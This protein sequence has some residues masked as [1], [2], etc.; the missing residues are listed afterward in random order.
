M[1]SMKLEGVLL[2]KKKTFKIFYVICQNY[3]LRPRFYESLL[4]LPNYFGEQCCNYQQHCSAS[5][6]TFLPALG[7]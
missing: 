4:L 5:L 7:K 3:F 1:G 2:E 6:I